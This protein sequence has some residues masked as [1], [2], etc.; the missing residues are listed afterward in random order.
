MSL[1]LEDREAI[2]DT[3][4]RLAYISSV[5]EWDRIDEVF[6]EDVVFN[7]P[8]GTVLNGVEAVRTSFSSVATPSKSHHVSNTIVT[9]TGND[10]ADVRSK[11]LTVRADDSFTVSEIYDTVRRTPAGWRVTSR[12]FRIL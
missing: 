3:V 7:K 10:T 2:R 8:N 9:S 4:N 5:F 6:A 12:R 1:S 11:M